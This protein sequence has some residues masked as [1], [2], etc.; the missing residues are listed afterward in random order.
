MARNPQSSHPYASCDVWALAVYSQ[1][2]LYIHNKMHLKLAM[3]VEQECAEKNPK[4]ITKRRQRMLCDHHPAK[5]DDHL[6]NLF[7]SEQSIS[8]QHE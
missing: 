8:I 2:R 3:Q 1:E 4:S 7:K 6:S 5:A